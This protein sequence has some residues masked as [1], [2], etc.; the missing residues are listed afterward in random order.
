[1]PLPTPTPIQV[2][3]KKVGSANK[4]APSG[5]APPKEL[6]DFYNETAE[7]C[8]LPRVSRFTKVRAR[9]LK[10]RISE[11]G[12]CGVRQAIENLSLS[13]FCQGGNL[14]GWVADFDF[15]VSAQSCTRLIE[16]Y[17][18][19]RKRVGASNAGMQAVLDVVKE[20]QDGARGRNLR[21]E[22][23]SG[24]D[25][26]VSL[27]SEG[28]DSGGDE[29]VDKKSDPSPNGEAEGDRRPHRGSGNG[30]PGQE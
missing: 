23:G 27:P 15:V 5:A 29:A 25:S 30:S 3:S 9:K 21:I 6:V 28:L 19:D 12:E 26:V 7:G 13:K 10:E 18:S 17:Y 14:R 11:H 8:G 20:V 16:G 4:S 2:V 22:G 24:A 1:M